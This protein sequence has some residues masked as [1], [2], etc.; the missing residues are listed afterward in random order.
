MDPLKR[1]LFGQQQPSSLFSSLCLEQSNA[2]GVDIFQ[3]QEKC[4]WNSESRRARF[5]QRNALALTA[6]SSKRA[7][8]WRAKAPF[9]PRLVFCCQRSKILVLKLGLF[10]ENMKRLLCCKFDHTDSFWQKR[11]FSASCLLAFIRF[12]GQDSRVSLAH[13]VVVLQHLLE[14]MTLFPF[15]NQYY[16]IWVKLSKPTSSWTEATFSNDFWTNP[17]N[18]VI[19]LY[20]LSVCQRTKKLH[21]SSLDLKRPRRRK[22]FF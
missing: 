18:I 16:L 21:L 20:L 19:T 10:L 6:L 7:A 15:R 17:L 8:V 22:K 14:S 9:F 5:C 3:Q 11:L 13:V 2:M 1:F 12:F 4:T